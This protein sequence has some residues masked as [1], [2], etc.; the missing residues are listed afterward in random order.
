MEKFK[1]AFHDCFFP[2]EL[3]EAKLFGLINL[4]QKN[5]SV[6]NMPSSSKLSKYDPFLVVKSHTPNK[7][8][9]GYQTWW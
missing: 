1:D 8:I 5:I 2:L 6:K 3:R 7:F 4:K 9:S